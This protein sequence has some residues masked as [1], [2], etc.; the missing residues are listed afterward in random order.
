VKKEVN[1][2]VFLFEFIFQKRKA[3]EKQSESNVESNGRRRNKNV[4]KITQFSF[5]NPNAE[6]TAR[7]LNGTTLGQKP[8]D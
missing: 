2:K 8:T 7:L 4:F 6:I 5:T 3:Y 1:F